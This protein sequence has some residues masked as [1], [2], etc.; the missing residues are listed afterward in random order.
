MLRCWKQS[1]VPYHISIWEK[2][3]IKVESCS[4]SDQIKMLRGWALVADIVD[5]EAVCDGKLQTRKEKSD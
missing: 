1:A 3:G 2:T 5:K 4:L